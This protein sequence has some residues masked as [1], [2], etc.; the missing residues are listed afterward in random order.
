MQ[1]KFYLL[2]AALAA[3]LAGCQAEKEPL[4]WDYG[5][6]YHTVF[7]NQ[8]IDPAAGDDSPVLG[9]DGARAGLAYERMEK[10]AP[11]EK[12]NQSGAFEAFLK[13]K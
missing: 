1:C 7:E 12:A 4:S 3:V 8:K 9:M 5:K 10:A 11:D 2:A 6:A 13:Q